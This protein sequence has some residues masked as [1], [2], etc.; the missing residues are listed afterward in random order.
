MKKKILKTTFL[1][2]MISAL[3]KILSFIIRIYIAR[4]LTEEALG[5]YSLASS[6]LLFMI[7]LSN[8][9]IPNALTQLIA[10]K[11]EPQ[12][13]IH[14]AIFISLVNNTLLCLVCILGIPLYARFLL[15]QNIMIPVLYAC[16]PMLPLVM[17]T[18]LL[19]GYFTGKQNMLFVS[20]AQITEECFRLIFLIAFLPKFSSNPVMMA[21]FA[22]FSQSIGEIGSTLHLSFSLLLNSFQKVTHYLIPEFEKTALCELLSL[23]V[24]M[25][26]ARM[27]GS[28][29]AFAEPIL[30]LNTAHHTMKQTYIQI[31]S[32]LN[33]YLLPLITLPSFFTI[34]LSSWILPAFSD[35]YHR[36]KFAL[37]KSIFLFS[38][39]FSFA[40]G[41]SA[42]LVFFFFNQ[43]ICHLLFHKTDMAPLL[44]QLSLPFALYSLQP[45]FTCM[46]HGA[47]KSTR[48]MINTL[49]GCLFRLLVLT[50]LCN[51]NVEYAA[52]YSLIASSLLTTLLHFEGVLSLFF[53]QRKSML[54]P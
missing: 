2:M 15:H 17:M 32:V 54:R 30:M 41:L 37:A 19:K 11:K 8:F 36:N 6:F 23:S 40:L 46:L 13:F 24:P 5:Y 33:N 43:E 26:A 7:A 20:S 25:T 16:V 4:N 47:Q 53:N 50:V 31:Y 35:A 39:L 9:G 49:T 1:L 52:I 38:S 18:G 14:A 45:V 34:A 42:S 51:R 28:L 21:A 22:L 12:S 48:A 44:K 27:I 3:S 29:T 10:S